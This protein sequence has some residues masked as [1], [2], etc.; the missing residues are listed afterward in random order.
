[1]GVPKSP[2]DGLFHRKSI[3]FRT[4]GRPSP[5]DRI[6]WMGSLNTFFVG[7]LEP[8]NF[9]TSPI[10]TRTRVPNH[11]PVGKLLPVN[12]LGISSSQLTI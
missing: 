2:L 4:G 10:P 7:A 1:M 5:W 3:V 11:Q 6:I 9:M 12:I 8:W